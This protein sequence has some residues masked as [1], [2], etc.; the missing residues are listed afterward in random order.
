MDTRVIDELTNV[1]EIK[2]SLRCFLHSKMSLD[3]NHSPNAGI[4]TGHAHVYNSL[5]YSLDLLEKGGE[6]DV[7]AGPRP[8]LAIGRYLIAPKPS[9][10]S[11]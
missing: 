10:L 9:A 8:A 6:G 3:S 1:E 11:A 5:L 2:T 7:R 4:G